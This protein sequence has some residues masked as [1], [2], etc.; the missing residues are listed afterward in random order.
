MSFSA[1]GSVTL[2]KPLNFPFPYL[3]IRSQIKQSLGFFL[4][5]TSR[6]GIKLL[7]GEELGPWSKNDLV[8]ILGLLLTSNL[9]LILQPLYAS[10]TSRQK[11]A[12]GV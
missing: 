7:R 12:I 10:V 4:T 3:K 2:G 8:R 5:L 1:S 6:K 9:I 11:I